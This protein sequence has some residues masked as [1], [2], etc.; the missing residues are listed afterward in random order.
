MRR[1]TLVIVASATLISGPLAASGPSASGS[2]PTGRIAFSYRFWPKDDRITDNWEIFVQKVDGDG[3]SANL[4]RNPRCNEFAPAWSHGGRL[5]AFA[6][7]WGPPAGIYV[8]SDRGRGRRSVVKLPNRRV[9]DP[10]WAPGDRTLAFAYSRDSNA[11]STGI[12]VV[13]ANGK[14]LR[15]LT[16]GSDGSPSWS[17]DGRTIVF[18]RATRGV[19]HVLQMR[20]DGARQH[21]IAK[22]ACC[23]AWSPDGRRIA[24]SRNGSAWIMNPDGRG[25]R[26][27]VRGPGNGITDLAWSPDARYLAYYVSCCREAGIY[28][29]ALDGT[30]RRRLSFGPDFEG[31]AWGPNT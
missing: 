30:T 6:C 28:V 11:G 13:K 1:L 16:G 25:Q 15:R 24:F 26:R 31:I 8:M 10:A 29:M 23:P 7:A 4:T 20:A 9:R 21:R 17:A 2:G 22:N 18:D 12:W 14:G 27:V 3:A 5:I 19:S